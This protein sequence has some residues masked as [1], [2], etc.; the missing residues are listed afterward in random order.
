MARSIFISLPV[1]DVARSTAFYEAIGFARN[2]AL[3]GDH[4]SSMRWSDSISINLLDQA[5]YRT[6]TPKTPVDA[7]TSS[8][9]LFAL[10]FDSRA[11][12]DAITEAAIA[13]GGSEG[14]EAEDE[15][16]MYSRA[17]ADPDGHSFG[18]FWMEPATPGSRSSDTD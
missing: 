11:D 9:V 16:H 6:L 8:E 18:P 3:S 5:F 1:E 15:G 10:P 12:V 13:A 14:H 2:E 7:R 4:G 17:F